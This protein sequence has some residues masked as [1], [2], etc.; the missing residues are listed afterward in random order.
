MPDANL[1]NWANNQFPGCISGNYI[2]E[3]HPGVQSAGMVDLSFQSNI[4]NLTGVEA[5]ASATGMN[6][7][8]NP[9]TVW[10]YP[11]FISQ[12]G[13]SNCG[14]TGTFF[15]P[16]PLTYVNISNNAITS[17][18]IYSSSSLSTLIAHHNQITSVSWGVVP[19]WVDLSY[20]QLTSIG[21]ASGSPFLQYLEISHNNFTA[22]PAGGS[23][24]TFLGASWNQIT[25]V[26][27]LS[28]NNFNFEADLSHNAIQQV[29][30]LGNAKSVDLSFNPLTLGISGT[31]FKLQTLRVNNTQLP[32]LPYLHFP[33]VNLYCANSPINCIPNQPPN[34]VMSAA[35]FGFTPVVCGASSPCYMA[36]PS[37]DL[38]VFLQGPYDAVA[39]QMRDDL[40]AQGLLP[41]VDPY[42][43]LGVS[44]AGS[45]WPD[46][47]SSTVYSTTG[48]NAIVDWIVVELT[49]YFTG[50]LADDAT[51]YSRPAFVQ[52]DGD[53]VGLDGSWPLVMNTPHGSYRVAVR[54]RN[55]LGAITTQPQ[56]LSSTMLTVDFTRYSATACQGGAMHGDS[57]IADER[58]LWRGDVNYNH[59]VKYIGSGNDRDPILTA[60][61]GTVPTQMVS[62]VYAREDVNMDGVIK[63]TGAD[64]DRDPILQN[65]GGANPTAVRNQL[66]FY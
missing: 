18:V 36:T 2:D 13:A 7:S 55:H 46:V 60:I 14:V 3:N 32:C 20:N 1:R 41:H 39:V 10:D 12:L 34:L 23:S 53:V 16:F 35:N 24:L 43:T 65:I 66:G 25:N 58:Q 17:L 51:P 63:Y 21:V 6:V 54:H 62:G 61:G 49:P 5:F 4:T 15:I 56:G 42:P 44:Y 19:G 48:P 11:L 31:S 9:I 52:R 47:F 38:R 40:R 8:N 59:Q 57:L 64:N 22:V 29:P 33:L 27:Q 28:G 50:S 30:G 26:S 37:L 45:G